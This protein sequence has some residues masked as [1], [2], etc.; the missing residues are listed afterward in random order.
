MYAVYDVL[1]EDY[2]ERDI[3]SH[4]SLDSICRV[5]DYS[6]AAS[7]EIHGMINLDVI[8]KAR[9][10]VDNC[11]VEFLLIGSGGKTIIGLSYSEAPWV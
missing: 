8:I 6:Y 10:V 11:A 5:G 9:G 7:I 1:V 2:N 4:A 3:S